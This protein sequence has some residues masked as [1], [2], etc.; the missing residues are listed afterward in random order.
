MPK[1]GVSS[2]TQLSL[3]LFPLSIFSLSLSLMSHGMGTC[4]VK[5]HGL[6]RCV[7]MDSQAD[8][9]LHVGLN[10]RVEATML[11]VRI[12]QRW[13][14]GGLTVGTIGAP[15]RLTYDHQNLGLTPASLKELAEGKVD[16][17]VLNSFAGQEEHRLWFT[18]A[19]KRR[20]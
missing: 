10:A 14:R 20:R 19:D 1:T 4:A 5:Y 12:R 7:L 18:G 6:G 3:S 2:Y 15:V 17:I 13:L 11:N 16:T 9:I 8:L